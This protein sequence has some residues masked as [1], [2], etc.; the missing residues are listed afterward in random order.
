MAFKDADKNSEERD[1]LYFNAFTEDLFTWDNDLENNEKRVLRINQNS[2]FFDGLKELEMES[3]IGPLLER[4]AEFNF[5]ID[6]DKWT[7]SFNREIK[8]GDRSLKAEHIKV[9]RGEENIFIWCFFLAIAQLA[10]EGQKAYR[11]VKYLY[12]DDPYFITG[13]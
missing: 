2:H 11:W 5:F 10:I 3:R 4:Y 1:T 8:E 7:I 12:V 6:Y 13:R 9:S